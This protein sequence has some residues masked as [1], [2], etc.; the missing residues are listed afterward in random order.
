MRKLEFQQFFHCP[1]SLITSSSLLLWKPLHWHPSSF[2]WLRWSCLHKMQG[3]A[4]WIR[5]CSWPSPRQKLSTA[6]MTHNI[7][8]QLPSLLFHPFMTWPQCIFWALP[9]LWTPKLQS[10]QY[11]RKEP[12]KVLC[13]RSLWW[14]LHWNSLLYSN[15]THHENIPHL[16]LSLN[17]S[18]LCP[19][20]MGLVFCTLCV[21]VSVP[22]FLTKPTYS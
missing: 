11:P 5:L 15:A 22:W 17:L 13:T 8:S 3:Y 14:L 2:L 4:S 21:R 18:V 16:P 10:S 6:P 7:K 20:S 1:A 19:S 9:L 12:K